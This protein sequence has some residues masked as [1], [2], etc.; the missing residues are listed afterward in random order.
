MTEAPLNHPG[1]EALRALSLGKL[2]EPELTRVSAHLGDC[3]ACCR[4][5]DQLVTE[6]RLVARLQQG[7]AGREKVLV[8]PAQRRAAVCAL[9]RS[10]EARSA[11]RKRDPEAGTVS[12]IANAS[13]VQTHR[14]APPSTDLSDERTRVLAPPERPDEIGRLGPY[15]I[16]AVLAQG[17][18]GVVFRGHDPALDRPVALKTMLPAMAAVPNARERFLREARAAAALKHPHVVTIFQVGEDRGVPFLAVEFL[19]GESLDA[20]IRREGRL[21]LAEVLRIG[22]E[23]ALGLA[24]AHARGLVHRDV[25]PANLWLEGPTGQVKVLDFGLARAL[26]DQ[27][28]LTQSGLVVGTPAYMAP[29]Q[30]EGKPV[31]PRCDLF[32]LGCVLY[33]MCTGTLPFPGETTI[34]VLR[35]LA[36]HEPPPLGALRPDA[37]RELS[38]LVA[39]LLAKK[40]EDRPASAQ[41]VAQTLHALE[42]LPTMPIL[43]KPG[44]RRARPSRK[45]LVAVAGAALAMVLALVLVLWP[46]PRGTVRIESDDPAVEVVFDKDGPTI[47]GADKEPIALRAGEH[48]VLIKR[49]DFTFEADKLVLK[50]GAA[51]TLKVELLQGKVQV[52]QDG[53]VAATQDMFLPPPP[54]A[55][56]PFDARQARDRQQAWAKYLGVPV[57]YTNKSGMKFR[58]IPPG[59]FTMGLTE[60]D[61]EGW[62]KFDTYKD[63]RKIAVPAHLV[64]LTRPFYMGE[65][66]VRYRDFLDVMKREPGDQPKH[67]DHEPDGVLQANCTWFDCIEFCNRLSTREGLTPAYNVE[68]QEVTVIPRATGYRLPTEAEW[69]FACRAGTTSLWYFGWTA[70]EAQAMCARSIPEAQAYLRART[71]GPNPFGLLGLYAGAN[72]WCWDWYDPGYYRRCADRGVAVDPQGPD[73]GEARITR[74]GSCYDHAS[75][76]LTHINSA[77][78]DPKDSQNFNGFGRV[79]LPIPAKGQLGAA[80]PAPPSGGNRVDL[81]AGWLQGVAALPA[82]EQVKAVADKLKDLNPGFDGRLENVQVKDGVVTGLGFVVDRVTDIS[83]LRALPGL[84]KLRCDGSGWGKGRLADLSP[85]KGLKLTHLSVWSTKASD[86]SPLAGMKLTFLSCAGSPVADLAPLRGMPLEDLDCQQ[87]G[88]FI[89]SLAPLEGM[90]LRRLDISL[91]GVS[92]LSPLRGMK[93]KQLSVTF[94]PVKDLSPLKG[95]PLEEFGCKLAQVTDLS[96]LKGMPLKVLWCDF[97]AERD[98]GVL[99]SIKTL[100][101]IDGKSAAEFWKEVDARPGAQK[102]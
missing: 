1:D 17:G 67:R 47:K 24:A 80:G 6:D 92:D 79:V 96:P 63:Y 10:H 74:G 66:E 101:K 46:T 7:A 50:K 97:K 61:V 82:E 68:A 86:L 3:P 58:L 8:G 43:P 49:G 39:R 34:A 85:L 42:Q 65:G 55:R 59:E 9:R 28:H 33:Q 13:A 21:P 52:L 2:A 48:G 89:K 35:A 84:I 38:A 4:R 12:E 60:A 22:R 75:G 16:L 53:R 27:A 36:L 51:L 26:A 69:E 23:T 87:N 64:R 29:E 73:F 76:H 56:A 90:P 19:E 95:M 57:E 45:L 15:R 62:E 25:K 98:A 100:E 32:S 91:T 72:E 77:G 71:T 94:C 37:P 83:P 44:A 54:L 78:R 5:I 93:L 11:T 30:A 88:G 81:L 18:M 99:R 70:K 14:D 40:P 31:D 41:E 102:P 20:R